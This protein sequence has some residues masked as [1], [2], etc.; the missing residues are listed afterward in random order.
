[1]KKITKNNHGRISV[2]YVGADQNAHY[3]LSTVEDP[4]SYTLEDAT[5]AERR[6]YISKVKVV[7]MK[8]LL[9]QSANFGT[10]SYD[11]CFKAMGWTVN[12]R[13]MAYYNGIKRSGAS[14]RKW[15]PIL[16]RVVKDYKSELLR[17]IGVPA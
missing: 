15:N 17:A 9:A 7:T 4:D 13:W 2:Y 14:N 16:W 1:M 10:L 11:D 5:D 12:N 3:L 8:A 6:A